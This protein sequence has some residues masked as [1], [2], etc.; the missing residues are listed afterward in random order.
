LQKH[1]VYKGNSL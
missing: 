1:V